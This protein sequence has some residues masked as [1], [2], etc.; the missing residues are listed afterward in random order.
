MTSAGND[1]RN[2]GLR[3]WR[4]LVPVK[5]ATKAALDDMGELRSPT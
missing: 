1:V 3:F 5:A 4:T 2:M